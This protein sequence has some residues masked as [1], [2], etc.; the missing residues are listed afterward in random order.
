MTGFG[1][2]LRTEFLLED[3]YTPLNHGSFGVCPKSIRQYLQHYQLLSELNP[4]KF[5]RLEM[6]P[7]LQKNKNR[8]AELLQ[9]DPNE[10]VFVINAS[11]GIN[12]VVRSLMLRPNEKLLCFSTAYD[13]VEKTLHYVQDAHQAELIPIQ[14]NYPMSDDTILEII[15]QTIV[16]HHLPSSPIKLCVMD[17]ITSVPGV[18][19]PFERVVKLLKEYDILSLVDGAHAI[20][21]IPLD[22]HQID[23]DFFVT[24][25]HKWLFTPRGAA[26]LYVPRRNQYMIHPTIINAAYQNHP[27]S[28]RNDDVSTA[29]QLEF[30]WPGTMDFSSFMCIEHALDFRETLGGEEKIQQ[31]CHQLAVD[32]GRLVSEILGTNVMENEENSLTVAMVNVRLPL[33]PHER[34]S[35]Q[36]VVQAIISKLLYEHNC[37]GSPFLHNNTWY[38][39]LSAQVYT[40]MEDFE[41]IGK[42]LLK[43]CQELEQ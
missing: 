15:Q 10:L 9:C 17:A 32:G 26:I 7:L 27:D 29:F 2:A 8:L 6:F 5:L 42:A 1:R 4:D 35:G 20:G 12:A 41:V 24:N 40:D 34:Y 37:M 33:N 14:L 23:P 18:R 38:V 21:Q 30:S 31:Y 36:E 19:F 39:R 28:Q 13:A 11:S 43:V 16:Q 25:C 3:G 22:L